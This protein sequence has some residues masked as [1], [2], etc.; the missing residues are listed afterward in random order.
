MYSNLYCRIIFFLSL[1]D[2]NSNFLRVTGP[3]PKRL[4]E[5]QHLCVADFFPPKSVRIW[6]IRIYLLHWGEKFKK[7]TFKRNK[8]AGCTVCTVHFLKLYKRSCLQCSVH[9]AVQLLCYIDHQNHRHESSI[10]V[11]RHLVHP[12]FLHTNRK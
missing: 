10:R 11:F 3:N 8:Y 2:S 4:T 5:W 9:C 7:C 1:H 12:H 6:R